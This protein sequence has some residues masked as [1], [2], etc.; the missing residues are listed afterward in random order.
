[1]NEKNW[2]E[3]SGKVFVVVDVLPDGVDDAPGGLE[4][5]LVVPVAVEG[6]QLGGD[7]VVLAEHVRVQD[8]QTGILD[9]ATV[10]GLET[11]SRRR[12][13]LGFEVGLRQHGLPAE[14]R[15]GRVE[16][17]AAEGAQFVVLAD[18]LAVDVRRVDV[19]RVLVDLLP[20]AQTL[21]ARQR[22]RERQADGSTRLRVD[23]REEGIVRRDRDR[24][25]FGMHVGGR[26]AVPAVEH[27]FVHPAWYWCHRDVVV[28][29]LT[30][31]IHFFIFFI[32]FHFHHLINLH[33]F[34]ILFNFII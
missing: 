31:N 28:Q 10:A 14:G 25:A 29:E 27:R 13:T 22:A 11:E 30:Q 8:G 17:T 15:H 5:P 12:L 6:L 3:D 9:N 20:G 1:M 18:A 33:T 4:E 21:L 24:P 26:V 34:F 32:L 19:G 23:P 2:P 7:A 16:P